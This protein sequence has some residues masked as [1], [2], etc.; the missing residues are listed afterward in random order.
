M[1]RAEAEQRIA[2]LR[3]EIDRHNRLYYVE[4]QPEISDREYDRL[5]GELENLESLFPEMVE[6]HSPTQRIGG[7]ASAGFENVRHSKPMLSLSNTY[8]TDELHDFETRARS[9]LGK[10]FSV[11]RNSGYFSVNRRCGFH[12]CP[13]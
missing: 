1:K 4:A 12:C 3:D 9:L 11:I 10:Q 7:E 13:V 8:D 2:H 5:Y 6:A